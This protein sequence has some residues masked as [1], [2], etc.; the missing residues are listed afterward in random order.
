[1][2]DFEFPSIKFKNNNG[3]EIKFEIKNIFNSN[4]DVEKL[5]KKLN[6][7]FGLYIIIFI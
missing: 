6:L 7:I 2:I 1:M 5:N 3:S 4:S